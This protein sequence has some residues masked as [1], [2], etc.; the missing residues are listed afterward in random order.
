MSGNINQ[1]FEGMIVHTKQK[2]CLQ[3]VVADYVGI[4][5]H[6]IFWWQVFLSPCHWKYVPGFYDN[7]GKKSVKAFQNSLELVKK[8]MPH[9]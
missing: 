1:I 5:R 2:V 8:H 9:L 6:S 4:S 3:S 7:I